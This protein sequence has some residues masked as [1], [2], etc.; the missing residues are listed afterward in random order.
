[1]SSNEITQDA[2]EIMNTL[3]LLDFHEQLEVLSK[4]RL[5]L[6]LTAP[7]DDA[8]LEE[9]IALHEEQREKIIIFAELLHDSLI[10]EN[11]RVILCLYHCE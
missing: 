6:A 5:S 8:S 1:M 7:D 3:P 4:A 9:K 2:I 10:S 11:G